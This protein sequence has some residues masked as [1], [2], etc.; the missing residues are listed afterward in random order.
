MAVQTGYDKLTSGKP[1]KAVWQEHNDLWKTVKI[2]MDAK[3]SDFVIVTHV[4]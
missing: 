2:A 1:P 3:G 4:K